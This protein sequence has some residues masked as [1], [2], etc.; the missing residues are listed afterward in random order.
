MFD[1][2]SSI[3]GGGIASIGGSIIQDHFN[4]RSANQQRD[5]EYN[6]SGTA[7]QREVADLKAAGLNPILSAGGQGASTPQGATMQPPTINMPTVMEMANLRLAEKKLAQDQLR[8]NNETNMTNST[9]AKNLDDRELTRANTLATKGGI[10][11]KFLGTDVY[12]ALDKPIFDDSKIP[13]KKY[14]PLQ[15]P[16]FNQQ[17]IRM[18]DRY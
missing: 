3:I 4:R 18:G 10:G 14:N 9:I 15:V 5:W 8:V 11:T 1:G 17:N 6:M 12:K 2:L 7:H 13:R 16:N